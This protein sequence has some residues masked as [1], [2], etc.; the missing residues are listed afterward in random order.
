MELGDIVL[1]SARSDIKKRGVGVY[2]GHG[3]RGASSVRKYLAFLWNGK[4][5]TFDEP[6]WVFEVLNEKS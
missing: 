5:A 4:I 6:Y 3:T 1:I 2:L